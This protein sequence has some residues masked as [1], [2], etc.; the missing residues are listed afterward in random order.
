MA[1]TL[2]ELER[3]LLDIANSPDELTPAAFETIR[4]RIEA[5]GLLFKV[6]VVKQ[7]LDERRANPD[8]KPAENKTR[9]TERNNV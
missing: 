6:R 5:Q 8:S 9:I 1:S 4:K 3:V 7:G 2:D